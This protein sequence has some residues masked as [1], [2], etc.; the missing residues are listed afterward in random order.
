MLNILKLMYEIIN[1]IFIVLL[2]NGF[3]DES[4][5][6]YK[7]GYDKKIMRRLKKC[8][9]HLNYLDGLWTKND[10]KSARKEGVSKNKNKKNSADI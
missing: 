5:K 8:E 4:E 10:I 2:E 9:K 1:I 6:R 3:L 7:K